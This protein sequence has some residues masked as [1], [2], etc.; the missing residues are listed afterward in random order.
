MAIVNVGEL[1]G[2]TIV[3]HFGG[4]P[5]SI[6]AVTLGEALIGFSEVAY[7]VSATVDP[8]Q[9]IEVVVEQTGP[10]SFRTLL[11]R[12]RHDPRGLLSDGIKDV[13]WGIVAAAI[14]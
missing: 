11:R 7:G 13:F 3:L 10:G 4:L 6:D 2:E 9:D 12:V 8:G 1:R 5:G 14:F